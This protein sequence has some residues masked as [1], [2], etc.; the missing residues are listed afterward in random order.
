MNTKEIYTAQLNV[1]KQFTDSSIGELCDIIFHC[2]TISEIRNVSYNAYLKSIEI[3]IDRRSEV[4][5][6]EKLRI[7]LQNWLKTLP[8]SR[9]DIDIL[10]NNIE[11]IFNI[12]KVGVADFDKH[13]IYIRLC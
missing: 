12:S 13:L 7:L 10:C 3:V 5:D 2:N 4:E 1:S 9:N 6:D 8:V 11:F